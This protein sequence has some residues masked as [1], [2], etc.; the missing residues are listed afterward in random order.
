M[1][2]FAILASAAVTVPVY[3]TLLGWQIEYILNDA[4]AV[5]VIC[6]NEEQLKR[7]RRSAITCPRSTTS[8]S[9][10]RRRRCRRRAQLRAGRRERDAMADDDAARTWFDESR[11][12]RSPTISPRSSTP[13]ARPAIRRARCSRTATS[14]AT[15]WRPPSS[16]PFGTGDGRASPSC[17]SRTSSSGWSTTSTST[18]AARSRTPRASIKVG[19]NLREIRPH[20]FAAVPRLFEKMRA[21]DHGQRGRAA[22]LE[23]EDLQLGAR[24]RRAAAAVPRRAASRCRSA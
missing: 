5:A 24:R 3:P 13:R 11:A 12:A 16:L 20:L 6:S 17:R 7:C 23:A 15:S 8:S 19:D 10:I 9:A 4:G 14:P 1:A 2:D 21:R 22:G 18:A